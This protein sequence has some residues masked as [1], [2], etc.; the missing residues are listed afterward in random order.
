MAEI[1]EKLDSFDKSYSELHEGDPLLKYQF[2]LQDE[3][4]NLFEIGYFKDLES[5][6]PEIN[7]SINEVYHTVVT[8]EQLQAAERN[9][10]FGGGLDI[11]LYENGD[12]ETG[13]LI[14]IRCFVH[15]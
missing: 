11:E 6:L 9:S 2:I 3:Y 13:S 12:E 8:L 5:A 15:F 10:P 4:N 1:N 7:A 14:M